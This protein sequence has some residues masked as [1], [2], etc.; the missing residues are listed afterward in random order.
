MLFKILSSSLEIV[1]IVG[2]IK[3]VESL[4]IGD[5]KRKE[6]VGYSCTIKLDRIAVKI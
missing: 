5:M 4:P 3:E 6:D 1:K 2:K